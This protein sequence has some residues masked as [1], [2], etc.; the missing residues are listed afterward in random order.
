MAYTQYNS[1]VPTTAQ[2]RQAAIDAIR[3]NEMAMRDAIIAG[4]LPGFN[5]SVSGGTA[6]QPQYLY[7][8]KSTEWIRTT[9]T[10]GTTGGEAGN[11]TVAV[12]AYSS[13]S[14]GLYDTIGTCTWTYDSSGNVTATTWS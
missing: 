7:R 10:W 9:L 14:G 2:T 3:T 11:V 13:N 5:Y 12:Y 1:A 8:K 4:N 6:D